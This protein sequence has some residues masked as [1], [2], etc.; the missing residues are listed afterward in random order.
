MLLTTIMNLRSQAKFN[1]RS[2]A[3]NS[4]QVQSLAQ[5]HN[6]AEKDDTI[7]VLGLLCHTPSDTVLLA[8]KITTGDFPITKRDFKNS[9]TRIMQVDW[10]EPLEENFQNRWNKI[11]QDIREAT[12]LVI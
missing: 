2:R 1:L 3:S 6:V 7:K 9:T 11:A 4:T 12:E 10:G 8:S 5:A